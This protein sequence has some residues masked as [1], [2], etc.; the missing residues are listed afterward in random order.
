MATLIKRSESQYHNISDL[1][2]YVLSMNALNLR[3]PQRIY[4]IIADYCI[5]S[6]KD[7]PNTVK[8]LLLLS[9]LNI[10]YDKD[11]YLSYLN[12]CQSGDGGYGFLPG[13]TSFLENVC[14][15]L[16]AYQNL[17]FPPK[18]T[19]KI[20]AFIQRCQGRRGG[21]GRKDITL[22]TIKST[23]HALESLSILRTFEVK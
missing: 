7:L 9:A 6:L 20:F 10:S 14:Y 19:D 17:Q 8:Y 18:H 23:S 5:E 15:A 21:L 11:F 13:S 16:R 12:R 2:Y 22:P 1:Y 4:E 3:L